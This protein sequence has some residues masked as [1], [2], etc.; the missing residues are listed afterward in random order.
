MSNYQKQKVSEAN[1]IHGDYQTRLYHIWES[2]KQRCLNEKHPNYEDYGGRGIKIYNEW[3]NYIDFKRWA[4]D[5][6]YENNLELDRIDNNMGYYPDNCRF[7]NRST[8]CF[9]RRKNKRN[10]SGKTGVFKYKHGWQVSG[11]KGEYI[12]KFKNKQH[13]INKRIEWEIETYGF[14]L[15]H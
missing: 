3:L 5:N 6:E 15:D 7:T 1:T 12:G 2:M 14:S 10:K 8:Q 9:N 4:L 13:A 11:R